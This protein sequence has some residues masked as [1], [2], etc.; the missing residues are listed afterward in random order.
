MGIN[1]GA[2]LIHLMKKALTEYFDME[3]NERVY[4]EV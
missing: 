1:Y 4:F 2:K 3:F